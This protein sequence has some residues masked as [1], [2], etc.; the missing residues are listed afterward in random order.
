MTGPQVN[1]VPSQYRN[2]SVADVPVALDEESLRTHL[3]GR[4]VY[5]RTRYLVMRNRGS[6]AVV[7]VSKD[8]EEPLF[9]PVTEVTML[10]AAG[11]GHSAGPLGMAD[12]MAMLYSD[13]LRHD[14]FGVRGP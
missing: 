13:V 5:R 3:L 9:S 6:S 2:V 7:E 14:T 4:P 12:F 11:S 8:S 1:L 10:A